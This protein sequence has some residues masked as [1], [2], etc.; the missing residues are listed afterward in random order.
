MQFDANVNIN[1]RTIGANFNLAKEE[2]ETDF[3]TALLGS[4]KDEIED[5]VDDEDEV[6]DDDDLD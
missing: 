5:I 2:G 4:S 3:F 6:L 1:N